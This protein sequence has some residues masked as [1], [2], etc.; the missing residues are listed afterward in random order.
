MSVPICALATPPG[1]AGLAVIRVS[2]SEAIA[3]CSAFFRG[4]VS[5]VEASDHTIHYGWWSDHDRRIDAVT[6][7]V[8]RAPHSYTG[9]DVIEI[10]CHG[11]AFVVDQILGSLH[12]A[13]IPPAEPGEFTRRAFMNGK[14][15]LTQVEAVA[16]LIHAQTRVGAQTAARQLAGGFTRRLSS[17]REQLL[18]ASGLLEVELDFSEEGYEFISRTAFTSTLEEAL[19]FTRSL[20]DSATSAEVLRSGFYAAVV[21]FP[22]A[23]KSSLFNALLD[24]PR[25]I[26][27]HI[28]GT[29]RDYLEEPLIIDG[30]TIHLYDT[31]GLRNTEDTIELQGILL[32]SSL[33]EQSN[34]IL[35]VN[36]ASEGFDHSDALADNLRT[37]YPS[38]PVLVVQNKMDVLDTI[39]PP[40]RT[41]DVPS[42]T[43]STGGVES[44]KKH[45]L[46]AVKHSSSGIHDVLVNSRQAALLRQLASH[47]DAAKRALDA[48]APADL[49]A[50]DVRA[51]VRIMGEISGETWNPDILDTVFS[52][53]CIGK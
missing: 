10:G 24:R 46:Q 7:T 27:S 11:G 50:I 43:T 33:L 31:A 22:N 38:T 17:L 32:T 41:D 36:D 21:G 1:T 26:V 49:I 45:L 40:T 14:L 35:V 3:R 4:S 6:A 19:N 5:L 30:Y 29:T 23:G 18:Q 15:D 51:C 34:L 2:G 42:S 44:V 25:A 28:P 13:G 8:F 53:F 47:L 16:D 12:E 48:E 39:I 37:K 20:V 9:E 52:R